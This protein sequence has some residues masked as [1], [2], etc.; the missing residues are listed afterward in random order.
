MLKDTEYKEAKQGRSLSRGLKLLRVILM[1]LKKP[2]LYLFNMNGMKLMR[3]GINQGILAFSIMMVTWN[4]WAEK[5]IKLRLQ[6]EELR[7]ERSK[8]LYAKIRN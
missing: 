3:S 8:V 6:A 7:S 1:I 4:A 5:T 2:R